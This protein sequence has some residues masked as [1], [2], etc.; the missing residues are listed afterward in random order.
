MHSTIVLVLSAIG[1]FYIFYNITMMTYVAFNKSKVVANIENKKLTGAAFNWSL[2]VA[3][4]ATIIYLFY[5]NG[6]NLTVSKKL[7]I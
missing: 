4:V 7:K 3:I 6:F 2:G 1:V 5:V